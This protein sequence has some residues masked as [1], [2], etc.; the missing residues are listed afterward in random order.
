MS[1]LPL[2][3]IAGPTATGKSDLAL[4]IAS[5]VGGEIVSADSAQVFRGL[6]I[7]TAKPSQEDRRAVPHHLIDI[8]DPVQSFSAAE[9]RDLADAAITA[10]RERGAVPV[11]VGGTGLY[12]RQLLSPDTLPPV[13]PQPEVRAT[14]MAVAQTHGPGALHRELAGID[15]QA[16]ATIPEGNVRR[17]IRALEVIRATGE[18]ISAHWRAGRG[19]RPRPPV[20]LVV[21]TRPREELHRRIALRV[22][23]MI[24]RGLV[25][26]VDGL[27]HAG[28]PAAAQ[29]MRA[30]GY[31]ETVDYLA[32]IYDERE[33]RQRLTTATRQYAKRQMTWF[34]REP[35]ARWVDLGDGP[36]QVGLDE[37]LRLWRDGPLTPT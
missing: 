16:A 33:L 17:V 5:A 34:R 4:A 9:Y 24:V 14:L 19:M 26:E 29:S 30:L 28:V 25:G 27:L 18:P 12:I 20:C 3:V 23:A 7:G 37:V 36:A 13:P 32:G 21:C 15:P 22:D 11:V 10:I 2:L 6:D 8:R 1:T 35:E 31:K